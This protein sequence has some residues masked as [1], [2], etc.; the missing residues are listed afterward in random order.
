MNTNDQLKE[1]ETPQAVIELD[2]LT[3]L[4]QLGIERTRWPKDW[5]PLR[6]E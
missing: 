4:E 2:V 1:E 6:D 3:I 5:P